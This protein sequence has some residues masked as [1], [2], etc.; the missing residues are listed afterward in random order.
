MLF[1]DLFFSQ[2]FRLILT[3]W[4]K[5]QKENIINWESKQKEAHPMETK[6]YHDVSHHKILKREANKNGGEP[7]QEGEDFA[8]E[9]TPE[10]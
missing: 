4:R 10:I 8:P 6:L 7:W 5:T 2:K 3:M 9:S 1:C